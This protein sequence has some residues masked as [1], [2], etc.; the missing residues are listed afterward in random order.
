MFFGV[1]HHFG[2]LFDD[3]VR[4]LVGFFFVYKK[5]EHADIFGIQHF[6]DLDCALEFLKMRIK[7]VGDFD[8][9]ERRADRG[10]R[11]AV[12][13]QFCLESGNFLVGQLNDVLAV[14]VARFP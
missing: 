14:D 1:S 9:A 12:L 6:C 11:N 13:F 4:L 8:L 10:H 2:K 5:A 3:F 7:I